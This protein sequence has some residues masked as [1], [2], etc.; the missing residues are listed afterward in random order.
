SAPGSRAQSARVAPSPPASKSDGG[1]SAVGLAADPD[2][3]ARPGPAPGPAAAP[4]SSA[5]GSHPVR[6]GPST[7][8]QG[9]PAYFVSSGLVFAS[10]I[11]M[12]CA[13]ESRSL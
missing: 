9:P 7:S 4:P 2:I 10:S 5:D 11:R 13:R 6:L 3:A 1:S 12:S 8:N